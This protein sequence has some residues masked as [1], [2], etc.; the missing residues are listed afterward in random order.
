MGQK[1]WYH[2]G[3]GA[4]PILVYFSGD[5]DVHWGYDLDFD[6]WR[7]GSYEPF[8]RGTHLRRTSKPLWQAG[9]VS[10]GTE[11]SYGWLVHV[12]VGPAKRPQGF[13]FCL[14]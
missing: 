8:A 1:Q 3:L 6:P 5:W 7:D 12:E 10:Q 11:G 2:F 4:P 9:S 14:P 13:P